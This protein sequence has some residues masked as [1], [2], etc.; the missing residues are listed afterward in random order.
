MTIFHIQN[1]RLTLFTVN[2]AK[3]ISDEFT[4]KYLPFIQKQ[5]DLRLKTMCDFTLRLPDK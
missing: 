5:N 2:N 4:G 1:A 3:Q